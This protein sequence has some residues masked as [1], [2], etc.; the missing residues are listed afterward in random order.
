MTKRD[1][2]HEI[3]VQYQNFALMCE[4]TQVPCQDPRWFVGPGG[5]TFDR[6]RLSALYWVD[7]DMWQA[8]IEVLTDQNVDPLGLIPMRD[9]SQHNRP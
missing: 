7:E 9:L 4:L 1:F 6:M 5:Y 2:A 3:A 8:C